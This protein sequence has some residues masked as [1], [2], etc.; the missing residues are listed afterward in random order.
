MFRVDYYSKSLG[1]WVRY[2]C[3]KHEDTAQVHRDVLEAKHQRVRIQTEG[4]IIY[5][6]ADKH[7]N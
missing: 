5:Q 1:E 3:P 7:A 4:R 6:T 2:S